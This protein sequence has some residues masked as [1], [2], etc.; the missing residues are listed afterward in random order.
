[1]VETLYFVSQQMCQMLKAAQGPP[2]L[3]LLSN[4]FL[5]SSLLSSLLSYPLALFKIGP[6]WGRI[7]G[8]MLPALG[9]FEEFAAGEA[10][11]MGLSFCGSL[12]TGL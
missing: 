3:P 12:G 2:V 8:K 7:M 9:C 1:M 4:S 10:A 5:L 6:H 11:R